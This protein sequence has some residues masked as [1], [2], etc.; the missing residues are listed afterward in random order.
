MCKV[1][2]WQNM[3]LHE[4]Q[5]HIKITERSTSALDHTDKLYSNHLASNPSLIFLQMVSSQIYKD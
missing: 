3:C 4:L 5:I 2:E 1:E